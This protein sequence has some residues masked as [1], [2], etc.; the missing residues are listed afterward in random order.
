MQADVIMVLNDGQISEMGTHSELLSKE[1]GIYKKIY[2][3][4]SSL[5]TELLDAAKDEHFGGVN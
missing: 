1:N 5:E 2:D 4:Q 3:I